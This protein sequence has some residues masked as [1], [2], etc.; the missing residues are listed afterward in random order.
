MLQE[1]AKTLRSLTKNLRYIVFYSSN[2]IVEYIFVLSFYKFCFY[3]IATV[4]NNIFF[5]VDPKSLLSTVQ[6]FHLE[7]IPE[8]SPLQVPS[9]K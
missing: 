3:F 4:L 2:Y 5:F 8:S 9:R 6:C 1:T 7:A